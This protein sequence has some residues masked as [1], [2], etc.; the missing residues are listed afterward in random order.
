MLLALISLV[1]RMYIAKS[2]TPEREYAL[3]TGMRKTIFLTMLLVF[4]TMQ[5]SGAEEWLENPYRRAIIPIEMEIV[6]PSEYMFI[7]I[8]GMGGSKSSF[9]EEKE[10]CA[11]DGIS[12]LSFDLRGHGDSEESFYF[13]DSVSDLFAVVE[14]AHSNFPEKKIV[15][16]GHSLGASIACMSGMEIDGRRVIDQVD[17]V[18]SLSSPASV[19]DILHLDPAFDWLADAI[20]SDAW[21]TMERFFGNNQVEIGGVLLDMRAIE[22]LVSH[23]DTKMADYVSMISPSKLVIVQGT[24]DFIVTVDNAFELYRN[25]EEPKSIEI[26]EG[27]GHSIEDKEKLYNTIIAQITEP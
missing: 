23:S 7:F 3:V 11:R 9:G 2:I 20:E 4:A 14:F 17:A 8:H 15:I 22:D 10:M 16:V 27:E 5:M 13:F 19:G 26:F 25:A 18:I 6:E 24:R 21:N 12:W 1:Y